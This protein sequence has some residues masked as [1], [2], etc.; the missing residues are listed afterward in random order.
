MYCSSLFLFFCQL[1][2][3]WDASTSA[4][5]TGE[6]GTSSTSER[7]DVSTVAA[8]AFTSE[9]GDRTIREGVK[10]GRA[11]NKGQEAGDASGADAVDVDQTGQV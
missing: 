9:A 2:Q 10:S 3:P 5:G 11:A 6:A 8:K 4:T 1:S 7:V